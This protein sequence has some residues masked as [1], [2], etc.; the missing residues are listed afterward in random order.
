MY[1]LIVQERE[2]ERAEYFEK[3]CDGTR[4]IVPLAGG[5]LI[6]WKSEGGLVTLI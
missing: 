6:L 3:Y 4:V 5:I 2:R 1:V